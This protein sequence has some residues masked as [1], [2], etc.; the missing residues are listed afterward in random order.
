[1]LG[2]V[3]QR[4]PFCE[5]FCVKGGCSLCDIDGIVDQHCVRF[6]FITVYSYFM[7]VQGT[8]KTIDPRCWR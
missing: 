8:V 4:G 2:P 6:L 3:F 1:M 5:L 7:S